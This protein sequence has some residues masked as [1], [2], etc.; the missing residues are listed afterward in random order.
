MAVLL[1]YD[2]RASVVGALR[3][4]IQSRAGRTWALGHSEE[5]TAMT[6]KFT[7]EIMK[8]GLAGRILGEYNQC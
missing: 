4:L 5:L 3:L 6:T 1:Y 2:G 8:E 7:D